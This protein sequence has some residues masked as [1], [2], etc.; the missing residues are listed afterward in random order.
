[1][2]L[3]AIAVKDVGLSR[4]A[5]ALIVLDDATVQSGGA[6]V[7]RPRIPSRVFEGLGSKNLRKKEMNVR[8]R[9]SRMRCRE[10]A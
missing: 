8:R 4:C 3:L 7:S 2:V 1:M 6:E 5:L 10:C 9:T